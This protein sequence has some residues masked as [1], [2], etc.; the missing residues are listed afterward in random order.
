MDTKT[1]SEQLRTLIRES[2]VTP[3]VL[4]RAIGVTPPTITRFLHGQ[5]SISLS[6]IDK[7]GTFL[8]VQLHAAGGD[9]QKY[10]V[11][12]GRP[13]RA[14]RL[15]EIIASLSPEQKEWITAESL[16]ELYRGRHQEP[17]PMGL[18]CEA[19]DTLKK[20]K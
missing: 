4:A 5:A 9:M 6:V 1:I 15:A 18:V 16:L 12:Q 14:R 17:V 19:M 10:R 7:I 3:S 11:P 8:H 2:G 13:S 20:A